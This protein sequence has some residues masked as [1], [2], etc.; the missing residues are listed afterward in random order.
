M[1]SCFGSRLHPQ[2][3]FSEQLDRFAESCCRW[4]HR[5]GCGPDAGM[6]RAAECGPRGRRW[7][8]NSLWGRQSATLTSQAV[9]ALSR[10]LNMFRC[11]SWN[12]LITGHPAA[13]CCYQSVISPLRPSH[14]PRRRCKAPSLYRSP[15][16]GAS[17]R[18]KVFIM[19]LNQ[20]S[21]LTPSPSG[22]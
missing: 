6:N 2:R 17:G 14:P 15:T 20:R 19:S 1:S 4:I 3:N 9:F 18:D 13:E 11:G 22:L 10:S 12:N 16:R 21:E 8:L 7:T 5:C